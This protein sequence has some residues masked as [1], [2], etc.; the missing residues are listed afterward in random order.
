[1]K[2]TAN[3]RI[4]LSL[5][6]YLLTSALAAWFE[7]EPGL[8]VVI[9]RSG[10]PTADRSDVVVSSRRFDSEA[11]VLVVERDGTSVSIHRAGHV[12]SH[13]YEGLDRLVALIEA[14]RSG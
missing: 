3:R 7:K 12:E 13:R 6:P 5:D 8:E 14:R 10:V 1:V 9:D 2:T 11:T 4:I